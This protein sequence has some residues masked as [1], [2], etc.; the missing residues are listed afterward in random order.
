MD[1]VLEAM[2]ARIATAGVADLAGRA[3][4]LCPAPAV[5]GRV[6][7]DEPLQQTRSALARLS[8]DRLARGLAA[9]ALLCGARRAILVSSEED[10]AAS[11]ALSS[12]AQGTRLELIALPARWPMDP[13]S[14]ICDLAEREGRGVSAAGLEG[15][16]VLDAV[17]LC[18]LAAAIEEKPA[19][20]RTVTVAGHVRGPAVVQAP[21]GTSVEDLVAAC[22]GSPDPGW[23]SFEDG[24]LGGRLVERD[25]V[26]E[27]RT[28]G[29]LILPHDHVAVRRATTP[30][31]D[32]L[33][34]VASACA[35]CRLC[36]D[37]CTAGLNGG[38]LAPHLVMRAVGAGGIE[39]AATGA[40]P[41]ALRGALECC[42]CGVCT[43]VCPS[44][45]RPSRGGAA[46]GDELLRRGVAP[47][48]PFALRPRADRAGRRQSVA[49]LVERL[50]LAPYAGSLPL[51]AGVVLPSR[52]RVPP[53]GPIGERTVA[54]R[55]GEAVRRGDVV[56]LAAAGSREPD[57][58][59]PVAGVVV[60][61]DVDDGVT[62]CPR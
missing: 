5:I 30:L 9:A 58:R 46:V 57:L 53:C 40:A 55:A 54:V 33:G 43:T 52:L 3:L 4:E 44:A 20:R 56:A 62:I 11:Q 18:D 39:A 15:A 23:V 48:E 8:A 45:L 35:G 60:A 16:V 27:R 32:E 13:G 61:V 59:S 19:P 2:R 28:R 26:L 38:S 37:V 22:G 41:G 12:V 25:H 17:V 24:L 31:A 51:R 49:R 47:G 7:D 29:L 36:S 14:L 1:V 34:R 6:C 50:G 10:A 42:R 21:L